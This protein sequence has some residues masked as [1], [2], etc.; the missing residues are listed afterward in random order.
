L[1]SFGAVHAI[2]PKGAMGLMPIMPGHGAV[3]VR[4]PVD[5]EHRIRLIV[6]TQ[7]S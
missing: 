5:R 6:N 7:S 3:C 1:E 4:I 2:S